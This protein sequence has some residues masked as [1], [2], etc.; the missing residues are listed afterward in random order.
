M[1]G[2]EVIQQLQLAPLPGE[3]GWFRETWR[4][5]E[6]IQH[7]AHGG[8]RSLGTSILYLLQRGECSRLHRLPGVEI[9]FHQAGAPLEI[10]LLEEAA[11][12]E[13]RIILLGGIEQGGT[14]QLVVPAGA[15]QGSR[16]AEGGDWSLVGTAMAPGFDFADWVAGDPL[17][18]AARYPRW[19]HQ[20]HSLSC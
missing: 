3:G 8:I 4:S 2:P 15:I 16:V 5:K 6:V 12:P 13:G 14:P 7:P 11:F 19:S 20:I 18:L 17:D 9:Y 1:T 10:L